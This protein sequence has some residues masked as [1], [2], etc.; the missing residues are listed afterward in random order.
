LYE[1]WLSNHQWVDGSPATTNQKRI[2]SHHVQI[3]DRPDESSFVIRD[4][5]LGTKLFVN[6]TQEGWSQVSLP[7]GLNGWIKAEH[8]GTFPELSRDSIAK[9]AKEFLGYPYFWGGRS[10]KGLDC[11][12]FTQTV[13]SLL[14]K[15]LPRDSWMQ[16]NKTRVVETDPVDAMKGHLYFF[17]ESGKKIT[18][19]GIALGNGKII[20]ARGMVRINSLKSGDDDYSPDLVQSLVDVRT[21][22]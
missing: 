12:G 2:R 20:H 6:F 9:L 8:F 3:Y 19:V 4:A 15:C 16:Q 14:G 7:D 5:V 10:I 22:F 13:Y 11:S 21:V 18:H 17:A 1:G